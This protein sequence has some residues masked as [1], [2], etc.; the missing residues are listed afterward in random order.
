[1]MCWK[2]CRKKQSWS[3]LVLYQNLPGTT[4]EHSESCR[5]WWFSGTDFNLRTS[6]KEVELLILLQHLVKCLHCWSVN[7]VEINQMVMTWYDIIWLWHDMRCTSRF[8]A[9]WEIMNWMTVFVSFS[10]PVLSLFIC[11]SSIITIFCW[12][13]YTSN[14]RAIWSILFCITRIKNYPLNHVWFDIT[15]RVCHSQ[16]L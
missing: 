5:E 3:I 6:K 13:M 2:V 7:R 1:M 12:V 9:G 15:R 11:C 14:I 16:S 10:Y 4:N 8:N